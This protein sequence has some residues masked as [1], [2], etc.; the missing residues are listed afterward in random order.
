LERSGKRYSG[1]PDGVAGTPKEKTENLK[2][3]ESEKCRFTW[4]SVRIY[5][6]LKYHQNRYDDMQYQKQRQADIK[7]GVFSL[8]SE[9]IH[10][11]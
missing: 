8:M 4:I 11:C 3:L 7:L 2:I 9:D 5:R 10:G 6:I 1:K